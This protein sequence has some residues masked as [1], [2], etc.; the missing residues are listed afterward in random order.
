MLNAYATESLLGGDVSLNCILFCSVTHHKGL[1]AGDLFYEDV[2]QVAS[3]LRQIAH[4]NN[5]RFHWIDSQGN[6]IRCVFN[7]FN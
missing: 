3:N 4:Q 7:T 1:S 5:G 6:F 2:D